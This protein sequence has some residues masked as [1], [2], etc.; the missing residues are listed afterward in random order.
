MEITL[1]LYSLR[2]PLVKKIFFWGIFLAPFFLLFF[3]V[4]FFDKGNSVC[5]SILLANIECYACGLTRGTMHFIHLDFEGAWSFNKLTFIVVPLLFLYWLKSL[6]IVM[7]KKVPS[8]L[9]KHM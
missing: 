6:F 4:D 8:F 1:R 7:N 5:L 3:P 9:D 2:N